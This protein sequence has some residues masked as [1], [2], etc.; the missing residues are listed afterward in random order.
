MTQTYNSDNL[1]SVTQIIQQCT[2][3]IAIPKGISIGPS[4]SAIFIESQGVLYLISAGH[5][6]NEND[7]NKLLLPLP[8]QQKALYIDTF[9][10]LITTHKSTDT[11]N[12]YDIAYIK[13][14]RTDKTTEVKSYYNPLSELN[15]CIEHK[16]VSG[17]SRY[18]IFGY[19]IHKATFDYKSKKAVNAAPIRITTHPV[20]DGSLYSKFGYDSEFYLLLKYQTHVPTHEGRLKL[21]KTKGISGCGVYFVPELLSSKKSHDFCLIGVLTEVDLQ[22]QYAVVVRIEKISDLIYN[23]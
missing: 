16:E 11:D 2:A 22:R 10:D 20:T 18:F 21:P 8:S 1:D 17:D 14:K 7:Y 5:L 3:Q 6:F 19:P 12:P 9:G 13:F 15:L 4:G 23:R